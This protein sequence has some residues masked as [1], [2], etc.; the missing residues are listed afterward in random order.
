VVIERLPW[1]SP[2]HAGLA[3][4]VLGSEDS[5]GRTAGRA[6]VRAVLFELLDELLVVFELFVAALA[7]LPAV[8]RP[9]AIKAAAAKAYLSRHFMDLLLIQ[10]D[11]Q[12]MHERR[13][14]S[15]QLWNPRPF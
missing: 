14:R 11:I 10:I 13:V 7:T 1:G 3:D 5:Q 12:A 15:F 4:W 2:Q 9:V 8:N 6:S